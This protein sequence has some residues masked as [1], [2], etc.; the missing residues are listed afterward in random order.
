VASSKFK[1]PHRYRRQRP[2]TKYFINF[3]TIYCVPPLVNCTASFCN[4]APCKKIILSSKL[5]A[6]VHVA[7][8]AH[9][10]KL[11]CRDEA[12]RASVMAFFHRRYQQPKQLCVRNIGCRYLCYSLLRIIRRICE[13]SGVKSPCNSVQTLNNH[14]MLICVNKVIVKQECPLC[15][16]RLPPAVCK[17]GISRTSSNMD[18]CKVLKCIGQL[19]H[20]CQ[21]YE[22]V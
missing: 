10:S 17:E 19:I 22:R 9:I 11:P 12:A 14:T 20:A 7:D 2:V 3:F 13:Y 18:P 16:E 21:H 8:H 1:R 5:V 4:N 15:M 6:A